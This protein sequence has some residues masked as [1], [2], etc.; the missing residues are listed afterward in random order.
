M[1]E[2]RIEFEREEDGRWIA[3]ITAVPGVMA[4]GQ[5]ANDALQ[6]VSKLLCEVLDERVVRI[7]KHT[8]QPQPRRSE[9]G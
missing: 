9:Y 8:G 6:E 5:T 4:Y 7:A 1:G 3:E 2:I